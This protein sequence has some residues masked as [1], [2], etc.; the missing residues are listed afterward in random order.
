MKFPSYILGCGLILL[1]AFVLASEQVEVKRVIDGDTVEL[2]DGRS[3]RLIGVDAP[4][5]TACGDLLSSLAEEATTYLEG[6]CLGQSVRLEYDQDTLDD[7][8]RTLAYLYVE[9]GSFLNK[10]LIQNGYGRA[11]RKY[12]YGMQAE[13]FEAERVA[14]DDQLGLWSP[15]VQALINAIEG[16][17]SPNDIVCTTRT[18]DSYHR[19]NCYHLRQSCYRLSL[20]DA[21]GQG[22]TPCKVCRPSVPTVVRVDTVYDTVQTET[23][24]SPA[25]AFPW[26]LVIVA[27]VSMAVGY[28]FGRLRRDRGRLR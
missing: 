28:G 4:E 7:H 10:E 23:A 6:K 2:K 21:L 12:P 22:K 18:G 19:C 14:R 24:S 15:D 9:G 26:L 11:N 8:G 3:V 20:A 17:L 13:F 16:P 27:I 5:R 25:G 1:A